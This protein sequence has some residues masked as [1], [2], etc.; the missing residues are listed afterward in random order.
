MCRVAAAEVLVGARPDFDVAVRSLC[1]LGH[2]QG[3]GLFA[4][5][6]LRG[7][8]RTCA[9]ALA[10]AQPE[11][12][13]EPSPRGLADG[14][15]AC[16]TGADAE[17]QAHRLGCHRAA[18]G[19]HAEDA[20][21]GDCGGAFMGATGVGRPHRRCDHR[22]CDRIES[23]DGGSSSAKGLAGSNGPFESTAV[24]RPHRRCNRRGCDRIDGDIGGGSSGCGPA[25]G[26]AG[27]DGPFEST[28]VLDGGSTSGGSE[29][30]RRTWEASAASSGRCGRGGAD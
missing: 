10:G 8:R 14:D 18:G 23:D 15:A 6:G 11:A 1:S 12:F 30:C 3:S 24:G 29:G 19:D 22:G 13:D 21:G 17:R 5:D 26:P 16:D 28:A 20:R 27:G 9:R 7:P 4:T 25:E 2:R